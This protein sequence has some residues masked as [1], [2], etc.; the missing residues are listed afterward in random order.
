MIAA[1]VGIRYSVASALEVEDIIPALRFTSRKV[2]ALQAEPSDMRRDPGISHADSSDASPELFDGQA[3]SFD[4]RTGLPEECCRA[5]AERLVEF[6][7]ARGLV[8]E[9]GCGTGQIGRWVE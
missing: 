3:A 1:P 2:R 6:G 7:G 4:R 8:V 9:V 5:V